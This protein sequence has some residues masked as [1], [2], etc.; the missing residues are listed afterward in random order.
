MRES[1]RSDDRAA[2]LCVAGGV[3]TLDGR[4]TDLGR[5]EDRDAT[6]R[7]DGGLGVG[8]FARTTVSGGVGVVRDR[9]WSST[10]SR[11]E[12]ML[13]RASASTWSMD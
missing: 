6:G 8:V 5:S 4:A 1:G 2:L 10:L 13:G 7:M 12:S 9:S 3:V 11:I